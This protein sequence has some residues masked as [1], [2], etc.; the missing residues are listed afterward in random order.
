MTELARPLASVDLLRCAWADCE[1][2]ATA[3]GQ[4]AA[5]LVEFHGVSASRAL[6][7]AR[8][9]LPQATESTPA[10]PR[11]GTPP[12]KYER[13]TYVCGACG[14]RGHTARSS[15]CPKWLKGTDLLSTPAI[16]ERGGNGQAAD[17]LRAEIAKYRQK[18]IALEGALAV[19]EG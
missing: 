5:H 15:V 16:L 13:G 8:R 18:I 10:M 4:L 17:A 7:D 14:G 6:A 2:T 1:V 11:K 9:Q 3:V 19:L 12:A